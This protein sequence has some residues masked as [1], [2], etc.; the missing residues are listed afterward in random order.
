M[1]PLAKAFMALILPQNNPWL[2]THSDQY[3]GGNNNNSNNQWRSHK[4]L[5]GVDQHPFVGKLQCNNNNNNNN[6][7]T[8]R[9]PKF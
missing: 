4:Y 3:G 6:N 5:R 7:A 1:K 2:A 8:P 9:T